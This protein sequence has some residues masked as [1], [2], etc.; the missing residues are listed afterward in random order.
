MADNIDKEHLDSPINNQ[1]E[2]PPEE[3]TT[4]VD[5]EIINPNQ[6]SEKMEVHA[7]D[8]HKAPGHCK[9]SNHS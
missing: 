1:S 5:T 9:Q 2:N 7:H 8:L 6:E 4:T 3:I